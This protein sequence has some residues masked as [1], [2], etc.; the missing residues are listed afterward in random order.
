MATVRQEGGKKM[1]YKKSGLHRASVLGRQLEMSE[2][3]LDRM[4]FVRGTQASRQGG[5]E[6]GRQAGRYLAV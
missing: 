3:H 5:R 4:S 6:G 1:P 2:T